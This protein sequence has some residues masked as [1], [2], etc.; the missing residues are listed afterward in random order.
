MAGAGAGASSPASGGEC[1][2]KLGLGEQIFILMLL[3]RIPSSLTV[4]FPRQPLG[5]RAGLIK[6]A[7]RSLAGFRGRAAD[8]T[9]VAWPP[10]PL[11][12]VL[13]FSFLTLGLR[14]VSRR[15]A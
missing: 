13:G 12:S 14:D 3:T 6:I 2:G 7:R 10:T 8:L 5:F 9:L 15:Y 1:G 4:A 11:L